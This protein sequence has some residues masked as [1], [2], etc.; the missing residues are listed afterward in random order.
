MSDTAVGPGNKVDSVRTCKYYSND[1]AG[2][3]DDYMMEIIMNDGDCIIKY[4]DVDPDDVDGV[5]DAQDDAEDNLF[6]SLVSSG[7]SSTFC[8]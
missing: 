6:H 5:A 2:V 4:P 8:L 1:A 3:E 7:Q